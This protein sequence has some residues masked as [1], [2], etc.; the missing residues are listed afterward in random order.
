MLFPKIPFFSNAQE[1][2]LVQSFIA[3][4]NGFNISTPTKIGLENYYGPGTVFQG[5]LNLQLVKPISPPCCLRVILTCIHTIPLADTT[6]STSLAAE[7]RLSSDSHGN[8]AGQQHSHQ[9]IFEVEQILAEDVPLQTKRHTF[10]FN[11]KFPKVNLPA[12]FMVSLL[13]F[14]NST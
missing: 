6:S 11:I 3:P 13:C 12:S 14:Y 5:Q 7:A 4:T 8:K 9:T 10:I 1:D 2:T